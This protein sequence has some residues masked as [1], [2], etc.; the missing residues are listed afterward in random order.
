MIVGPSKA[1]RPAQP[2][3]QPALAL[4]VKVAYLNVVA[5]NAT[6]ER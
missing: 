5:F 6:D 3:T 4:K 2:T 1:K